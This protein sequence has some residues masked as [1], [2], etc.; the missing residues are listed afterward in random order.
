MFI[1][2]SE[3]LSV[4]VSRGIHTRLCVPREAYSVSE[5]RLC[6]PREAYGVSETRLCMPPEA[7]SADFRRS[8][9]LRHRQRREESFSQRSPM[10]TMSW[11]EFDHP[12]YEEDGLGSESLI[13]R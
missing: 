4:V 10:R 9:G 2:V 5:T 8:D 7:Y 1:C 11:A 13:I 3:H 6:M 12:C